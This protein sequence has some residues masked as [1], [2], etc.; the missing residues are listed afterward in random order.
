[1]ITTLLLSIYI[2]LL[3]SDFC[4]TFGYTNLDGPSVWNGTCR[5]GRRQSP[6]N[7]KLS[8]VVW[9]DT[10]PTIQFT[11]YDKISGSLFFEN[12]GITLAAHGFTNWGAN[13]PY[14]SGGALQGDY[15][16]E[17]MHFHWGQQNS[18]GS[19][20]TIGDLHY[21][22]ELHLVHKKRGHSDGVKLRSDSL[23]VLAIFISFDDNSKG[24]VALEEAITAVV[25]NPG[26]SSKQK[27]KYN[28]MD[29]L[30]STLDSFFTYEGSLTTPNCEEAVIWHVFTEPLYSTSAMMLLILVALRS[31]K[32]VVM[33]KEISDKPNSTNQKCFDSSAGKQLPSGTTIIR[34]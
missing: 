4:W 14:I 3:Q 20:H 31:S 23:A 19:E 1:M 29:L 24:L 28:L 12:N 33:P 15:V 9:D 22:V 27:T 34:T 8:S 7:F 26:R 32:P 5:I 11:N 17:S 25:D 16:L 10:L 6:I 13:R 21:P 2:L 18:S 30:P